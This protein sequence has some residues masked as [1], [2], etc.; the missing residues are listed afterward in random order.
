V[1]SS[2]SVARDMY[3]QA[4]HRIRM[5]DDDIIIVEVEVESCQPQVQSC[6]WCRSEDDDPSDGWGRRIDHRVT[7]M[8]HESS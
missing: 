2:Q 6:M 3:A 7:R 5:D 4:M 8:E 1:R